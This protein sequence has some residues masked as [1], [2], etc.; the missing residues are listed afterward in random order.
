MEH[1]MRPQR[2]TRKILEGNCSYFDNDFQVCNPSIQFMIYETS[3]KS[4]RQKRAANKR[5]KKEITARVTSAEKCSSR[6]STYLS[7]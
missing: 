4:L 1:C 7:S 5:G 6:K 3:I 2:F